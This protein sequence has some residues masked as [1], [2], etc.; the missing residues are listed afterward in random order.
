M[1]SPAR[2]TAVGAV[3]IAAARPRECRTVGGAAD[4]RCSWGPAQAE[5]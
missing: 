5:H 2:V 3:V 4:E 1:R